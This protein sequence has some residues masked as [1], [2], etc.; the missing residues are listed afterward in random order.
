[1]GTEHLNVDTSHLN[2]QG[3]FFVSLPI[4]GY[5][6]DQ[7]CS[8]CLLLQGPRKRCQRWPRGVFRCS[9]SYPVLEHAL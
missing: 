1:M 4:L 5:V 6:L 9:V 7:C 8:H 2:P 3:F